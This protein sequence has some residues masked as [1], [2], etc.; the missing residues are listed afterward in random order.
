M[1]KEDKAGILILEKLHLTELVNRDK[2]TREYVEK[3]HP[4]GEREEILWAI[5]G[6]RILILSGFLL[7]AILVWVYCFCAVPEQGILK[8]GMYITRQPEDSDVKLLVKGKEGE[9][10]WEKQ[11]S[12]NVKKREFS[13]KEKTALEKTVQNYVEKTLP[14]KNA[15]LDEVTESLNFVKEIP[16]TEVVLNWI[17]EEEYIKESGALIQ[18]KI[19]AEGVDTEIMLKAECRNWKKTYYFTVHLIPRV[20]SKEELA[21]QSVRRALKEALKEQASEEIVKLPEKVGDTIVAYQM[22][23]GKKSYLPVYL[24]VGLIFLMP[25]V[26]REQQKKKIE[27]REE[28]MLLDHPG[29]V[30]KVMLLLSAGLTVR[31]AVERLSAEYERERRNG[32]PVRYVYEEICIMLQE[33]KD[34]VSESR[35]IERFGRRCRLLPYLRFSSVISQNLK[36]GSEG[37]LDILEEESMEAL[38]QRKERALQMGEKAGT[39]LLFPMMLMLG[40]VMGIIMVPAFMTM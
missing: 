19:P 8:E 4:R 17:W 28:Q 32:G 18:E 22:E 24:I 30:N 36:K 6:R 9:E 7:I 11:I 2:A 27:Q 38:E 15:S 10:E 29:V 13:G 21:V 39:K 40:L 5:W 37:I 31:G 3:L 20:Y 34:G 16:G 25:F 26:W 12:V 35:A 33:M 23:A 14:G 1:G